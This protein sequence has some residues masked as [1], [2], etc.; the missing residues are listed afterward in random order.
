MRVGISHDWLIRYG[1]A[2]RVLEEL[3]LEFPE[4]RIATTLH[5]APALPETL[6]DGAPSLLQRIPR[7]RSKHEWL[8][9]VMPLAW[10]LRRRMD[11]IDAVISSSYCC[12]QAVRVAPG[13][14]HLS[15]CHTPMRYAWDYGAE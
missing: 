8:L 1:G 2:E 3:L 9:P 11:D 4:A 6:H 15:Y 12:A 13:I 7:V 14:P 10:R 5:H